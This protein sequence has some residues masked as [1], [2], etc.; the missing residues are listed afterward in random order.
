MNLDVYA[1]SLRKLKALPVTVVHAG[2]D[3][4]FDYAR[5][6]L[7]IDKYLARRGMQT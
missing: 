5:M 7:I 2:H 3:P 4:S 6:V 1:Q